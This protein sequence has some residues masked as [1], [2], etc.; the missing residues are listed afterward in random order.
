MNVPAKR[1]QPASQIEGHYYQHLVA[2]SEAL[3]SLR[4]NNNAAGITVEHPAAGNVDDIVIHLLTGLH[5]YIQVKHAVDATT[6]VGS[7]WFMASRTSKPGSLSLLQKFH[8]SWH[9]LTQQGIR[10]ELRLVTDRDIDPADPVASRIVRYTGL[11][12]P[13]I[14]NT[15]AAQERALWAKHLDVTEDEL[16]EFLRSLRVETGRS[17]GL[18]KERATTLMYA[19]GLNDTPSALDSAVALVRDW[20]LR[21][22]RTLTPDYVLKWAQERVGRRTEQG[23]VVVID[24]ID[25]DPHP[26]DADEHICFVDQYLGDEPFGRRQLRDPGH[27]PHIQFQIEEAA[28]RLR[29]TGIRRVLVRGAMRLPTWFVAGAAFREVSG[30]DAAGVQRGDIWSSEKLEPAVTVQTETI[31]LDAGPDVAVAIGVAADPTDEVRSH[32]ISAGLPVRDLISILPVSGPNP[33]AIPDGPTAA[34]IAV[35]ARNAARDLLASAP[36][37][38]N[39][40]LFLATPGALALLL[41]HRWNAM[42]PTTIYEHLGTGRGYTPTFRVAG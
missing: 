22:E 3:N 42:R 13:G 38:A 40:H 6:P 31:P 23:A 17:I 12:V 36:T 18:E 33:A 16:V 35:A 24:G 11:L 2:W 39:I 21:D 25:Y 34:A 41:G 4:P 26:E 32:I 30:F 27:W 7:K 28:G 8:R 14:C 10:P 29:G 20:V 19:M 1:A 37:T 5:R 9:N 15:A